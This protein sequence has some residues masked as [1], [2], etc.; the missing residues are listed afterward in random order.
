VAIL[1]KEDVPI[2]TRRKK[3]LSTGG[4]AHKT[5]SEDSPRK[6]R[7]PLPL[8]TA[9]TPERRRSARIARQAAH[10]Q[11]E[12]VPDGHLQ[13]NEVS[14]RVED[15]DIMAA[16]AQL[17]KVIRLPAVRTLALV[18]FVARIGMLPAESAA[19]LKLLEKGVS[20]EALAGLVLIE[21]PVELF[22][23]VI[24]GRW[25]ASAHPLRPY[26]SGY[27]LRLVVA[28]CTTAIVFFFPPGVSSL[29]D[30][31]AAFAALAISGIAT[32]F[33]STLMFTALGDFYNRISDPVMGGAYLTLLNTL[34]NIGVVVPKLGIFAAI[35]ALT[36]RR[37]SSGLNEAGW[38]DA[39]CG[40]ASAAGAADGAC[41]EAGGS[42]MIVRDGFYVLSGVAVVSG[43]WIAFWLTATLRRLETLPL[44]AWRAPI[45]RSERRK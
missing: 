8:A 18:L 44:T 2:L 34:A 7:S 10:S 30:A 31:P 14:E 20:K 38:L 45:K 12:G 1:K 39:A 4:K 42:C 24:A 33:S 11:R 5:V 21:F 36:I 28:A 27:R 25:A 9:P 40:P 17:F 43:I 37:C 26:F 3:D 15:D 23:A 32:S 35:D 29:K 19:A 16:Y 6:N 22:S 13:H 41:L